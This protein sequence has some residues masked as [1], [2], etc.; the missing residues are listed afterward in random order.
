MKKLLACAVLALV[1]LAF[2]CMDTEVNQYVYPWD[3]NGN[4]I[5][6]SEE[7]DAGETTP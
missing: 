5:P 4:G 7:P 3:R 2:G 1:V 6:D